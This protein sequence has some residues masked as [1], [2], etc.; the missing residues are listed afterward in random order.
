MIKAVVFDFDG[1]TLDTESSWYES[2]KQVYT[3]YGVEFPEESFF[4]TVGTFDGDFKPYQFLSNALQGTPDSES[5]KEEVHAIFHDI[6]SQKQLR[7]GILDYLE[8][9]KKLGLKIGLASSSTKSWVESYL[10]AYGIYEY[11][12]CIHTSDDVS[13]VKPDPE[14][15]LLALRSLGVEGHEAVAFE[16]SLHG[17]HAAKAAGLYGVV[18]PNAV[19]HHLPFTTHDWKLASMADMSLAELIQQI[20]AASAS[21]H[22]E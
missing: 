14:L 19:T 16:D 21:I 9:A 10:R 7:E 12:D 6:M 3:K 13:R 22:Q 17:L 8:S 2:L 20:E 4:Q 11:Y 15:Y 5:L 1:L 18:V